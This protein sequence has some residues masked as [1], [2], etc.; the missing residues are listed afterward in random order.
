MVVERREHRSALPRSAVTTLVF[1][2]P[3]AL[4]FAACSGTP[5]T[6]VQWT[7]PEWMAEQAQE[8]EQFV[9]DL[10]GCVQAKGW[11]V[12]VDEYAGVDEP[13]SSQEE[14]ERFRSDADECITQLGYDLSQFDEEPTVAQL[15]QWYE[16]ETDVYNCLVNEG[17]EMA[18]E[19]P[20]EEE[21]IEQW[22]QSS[23]DDL[24]W[25]AYGDPTI[26]AM[27]GAEV[28]QLQQSCPEPWV[29]AS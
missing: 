29:F 24:A 20:S 10:Q 13:F 5:Q 27:S 7:E 6:E 14:S 17:V 26:L 16:R 25:W 21:F 28:A 18:V 15:Q 3:V 2:L 23:S 9:L 8:R 19:P 11:N 1:L 12:T 22:L 4:L